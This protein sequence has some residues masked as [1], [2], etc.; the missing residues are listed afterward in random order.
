MNPYEEELKAR[1]IRQRRWDTVV[2]KA[3]SK[4][5]ADARKAGV[6]LHTQLHYGAMGID[7]KHLAIWFIAPSDADLQAFNTAGICRDLEAATQKELRSAGYPEEAL[8]LI[9]IGCESHE[10]IMRE[11]GGD[12]FHYF[13]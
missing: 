4:V 11:T 6:K 8:V 2:G 9:Y 1:E 5:A 3:I 7:P 13:K 12:Y 10:S